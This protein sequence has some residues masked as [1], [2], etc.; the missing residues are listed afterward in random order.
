MA[1]QCNV[2]DYHAKMVKQTAPMYLLHYPQRG[3]TQEVLNSLL[4]NFSSQRLYESDAPSWVST[5]APPAV[6]A[7]DEEI[8]SLYSRLHEIESRIEE[9][10]NERKS[11]EKWRALLHA[12]DTELENIVLEAFH[13]LGLDNAVAGPKSEWDINF[14]LDGSNIVVEVKGLTKG[15]GRKHVFD[16]DRHILEYTTKTGNEGAKGILI[17]NP[18]RNKH[19]DDRL[20]KDCVAGDAI[21]FATELNITL[22][23][24]MTIYELV[25]DY[26]EGRVNDLASELKRMVTIKGL[27][28]ES[29]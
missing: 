17:F 14:E 19:P 3:T 22:I 20:I 1:V 11:F 4:A 7:I 29:T 25:R 5:Y 6:S 12:T 9:L 18:L 21:K 2:F 13:L 16:L 24:T 26:L 10:N 15:L 8:T 28:L 23:S 27:Y